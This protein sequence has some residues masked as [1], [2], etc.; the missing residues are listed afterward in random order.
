MDAPTPIALDNAPEIGD[1]IIVSGKNLEA[2]KRWDPRPGAAVTVIDGQGESFRA[3][4]V[5]LNNEK[6]ELIVY[7]KM[8]APAESKLDITLLQAL[9]DKERMEIIIEKATELGVDIIVPWKAKHGVNLAERESKQP[10][11]HRWNN[12]AIK[13]AKQCRRAKIPA[14][15]PF[16]DLNGA[17]EY[18]DDAKAKFVLCEKARAPMKKIIGRHNQHSSAAIAVGPEGGLDQN[19]IKALEAGGFMPVSLGPR[20]LRTETAAI[21]AITIVQWEMGDLGKGR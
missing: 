5:T 15:M 10:K 12:R 21:A 18:A 3:R 14:I 2:L 17:I 4:V 20:V 16:T 9:P 6:A 13:A 8:T 11:A 7:E 1:A 19:E